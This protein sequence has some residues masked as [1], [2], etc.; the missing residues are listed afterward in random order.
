MFINFIFNRGGRG[1]SSISGATSLGIVPHVMP[2]IMLETL[3]LV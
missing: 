2:S 1:S 3:L